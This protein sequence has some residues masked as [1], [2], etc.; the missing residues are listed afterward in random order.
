MKT[1]L[2]LLVVFLVLTAGPAR[3]ADVASAPPPAV[4]GREAELAALERFLDLSDEELDQMQRA[5]SLLR[6]MGPEEKSALRREIDRFR[7][8]PEAERRQLRRGWGAIEEK[9]QDAWRRLMHAATPERRAE[10]QR[11]LQALPP[12]KKADLRRQL[13]EEF[14]QQEGKK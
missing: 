14:L 6:A 3:A 10:I 7:R 8:L 5:I 12:E 2:C 11:Q 1:H 9:V 13:A 4:A